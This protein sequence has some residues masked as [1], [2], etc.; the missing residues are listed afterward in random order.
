GGLEDDLRHA[1][2]SSGIFDISPAEAAAVFASAS[3]Q[4]ALRAGARVRADRDV[5]LDAHADSSAR[6]QTSGRYLGLS[7]ARSSPQALVDLENG[8]VV[9]AGRDVNAR[10]T[11]A[12]TLEMR[13]EVPIAGDVAG[14]SVS[15]GKT[16]ASARANVE[17]GSQITAQNATVFA[18]NV[19]SVK[20]VAI[21][22]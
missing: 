18:E 21:S 19:S 5:V 12:N 22:G 16:R 1:I 7:F 17:V 14:V 11:T 9:T 2:E 15:F 6:L 4:I 3:S 10:A 13:T 8:V 20:N